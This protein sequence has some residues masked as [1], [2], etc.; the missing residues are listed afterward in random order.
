MGQFFLLIYAELM[1]L[2]GFFFSFTICSHTSI[3]YI[4]NGRNLK[5]ILE[6]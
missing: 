4:Y 6:N 2:V 1:I 5:G 3:I